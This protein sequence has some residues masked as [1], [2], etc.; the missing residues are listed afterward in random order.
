MRST[1]DEKFLHGSILWRNK[2]GFASVGVIERNFTIRR[3]S[4]IHEFGTAFKVTRVFGIVAIKVANTMM[5]ASYDC[6][7]EFCEF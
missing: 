5:R 2:E 6:W 3:S 4:F 1:F 7:S